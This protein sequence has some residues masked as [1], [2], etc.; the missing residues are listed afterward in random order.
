MMERDAAQK[1]KRWMEEF[2]PS[3]SPYAGMRKLQGSEG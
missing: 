2:L 1:G 3:S